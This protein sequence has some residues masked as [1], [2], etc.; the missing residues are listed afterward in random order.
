MKQALKAFVFGT[1]KLGEE[2]R[3]PE[4]Y[5]QKI[6]EAI[7][8]INGSYILTG[9]WDLLIEFNAKDMDEYYDIAWTYGKFLEKGWGTIVSKSF[10]NTKIDKPITIFTLVQLELGKGMKMPE[11]YAKAW[12]EEFSNIEEVHA[13]VG[14]WDMLIKFRVENMEEYYHT[15]WSI[16]KYIQ[17]GSGYIVSKTI[18]EK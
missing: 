16:G 12:F 11:D 8:K 17:R 9:D 2:L 18:K 10:I 14:V 6:I 13:I 15:T 4:F 1:L 5:A 3:K 7:P